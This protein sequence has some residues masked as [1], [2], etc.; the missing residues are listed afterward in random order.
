LLSP[1][2]WLIFAVVYLTPKTLSMKSYILFLF[3]FII[4]SMQG[5]AQPNTKTESSNKYGEGGTKTTT[6]ETDAQLR[7]VV[8]IEIKDKDGFVR[9]RNVW[10]KDLQNKWSVEAEQKDKAGRISFTQIIRFDENNKIVYQECD[11]YIKGKWDNKTVY[12]RDSAGGMTVQYQDHNMPDQKGNLDS[13]QAHHRDETYKPQIQKL[14]NEVLPSLDPIPGCGPVEKL[15]KKS[16]DNCQP[17]AD[18]FIG[19]NYINRDYAPDRIGMNGFAGS[20]TWYFRGST[21]TTFGV[22]LAANTGTHKNGDEKIS[23][24]SYR[25]G[26]VLKFNTDGE[27]TPMAFILVGIGRDE[28]KIYDTKTTGSSFCASAGGNI[29]WFFSDRVGARLSVE[30][31]VTMFNDETQWNFIGSTGIVYRFGC[32]KSK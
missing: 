21:G 10:K 9:E 29:D 32:K 22:R 5:L 17:Q 13:D 8:T 11:A 7:K 20:F 24:Q 27:I 15:N 14:E 23:L 2:C 3:I 12:K 30:A 28:F 31:L 6:V 18:L 25:A 26:P 19:Y 16:S 1:Q 4:S